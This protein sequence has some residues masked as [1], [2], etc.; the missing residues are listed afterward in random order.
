MYACFYALRPI[1]N[2][3]LV[4]INIDDPAAA[5]GK[6][7]CRVVWIIGYPIDKPIIPISHSS[8][9]FENLYINLL[10]LF[11]NNLHDF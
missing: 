2:S 11:N 3:S 9:Y 4:N 10:W 1:D 5:F 6:W 7:H 8:V